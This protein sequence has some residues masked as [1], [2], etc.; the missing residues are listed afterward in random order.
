[1]INNEEFSAVCYL[2]IMNHHGNG[3]INAH[4]SY[5]RE[6]L[7][8]LSA[9]YDAYGYLDR[10]NQLEVIEYLKKWKC[11]IPTPIQTYEDEFKKLM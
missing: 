11:D 10:D 2:V 9:G 3:F 5:I 4:P 8:M 6:K 7:S 1:M